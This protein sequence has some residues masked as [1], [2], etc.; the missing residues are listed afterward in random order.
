MDENP[1][2]SK[3]KSE[4]KETHQDMEEE[5]TSEHDFSVKDNNSISN[6]DILISIN[7]TDSSAE[8][9]NI[10]A[11][12]EIN[13]VLIKDEEA[14]SYGV[15]SSSIINANESVEE[16]FSNHISYGKTNQSNSVDDVASADIS[17]KENEIAES[18][19]EETDDRAPV[20]L[21]QMEYHKVASN[22]INQR[23]NTMD[24]FILKS[25]MEQNKENYMNK[26]NRL[27]PSLQN[28]SRMET[29]MED[30][31]SLILPKSNRNDDEVGSSQE[32]M[33]IGL[34]KISRMEVELESQGTAKQ[35]DTVKA[36]RMEVELDKQK[37]ETSSYIPPLSKMEDNTGH[38][39]AA[40]T[41][42]F[43][44][45]SRIETEA[46]NNN[47]LESDATKATDRQQAKYMESLQNLSRMDDRRLYVD[48]EVLLT[49]HKVTLS[50]LLQYT[51]KALNKEFFVLCWLA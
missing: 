10:D 47:Y 44:K 17:P 18:S 22:L 23:I 15:V 50:R 43:Q 24:S 48:K 19:S 3:D 11:W 5:K 13:D 12:V 16:L 20:V 34:Q 9:P 46:E 27:N 36:S 32:T 2:K 35:S 31:G 6:N 4:E 41:S 33:N 51:S 29:E 30:R 26:S 8:G 40:A 25:N 21:S 42:V 7:G 14:H 28:A 49:V 39:E 37:A 45:A 38:A 1:T